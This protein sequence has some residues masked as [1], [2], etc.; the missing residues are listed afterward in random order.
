MDDFIV[1]LFGSLQHIK[2]SF[3]ALL[4]KPTWC[5]P[6]LQVSSVHLLEKLFLQA[7]VVGGTSA[8]LGLAQPHQ[9]TEGHQEVH[10]P[11]VITVPRD[12]QR[13]CPAP[14]DTTTTKTEAVVS[15]IVWLVL[16]VLSHFLFAYLCILAYL[17]VYAHSNLMR[18]TTISHLSWVPKHSTKDTIT[19]WL[20]KSLHKKGFIAEDR[21]L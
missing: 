8:P 15:L 19:F 14:Q 10:A 17:R 20:C 7:N 4:R 6:M 12:R 9:R 2:P 11:K 18:C 3:E 16:Q 21:L 5:F 13:H 1:Q